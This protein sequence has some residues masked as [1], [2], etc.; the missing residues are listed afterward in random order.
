MGLRRYSPFNIVRALRRKYLPKYARASYSQ[1]GE[2]IILDRFLESQHRG[3]YVDVGAHH[4]KRFSNT[5]RLYCRGWRGLNI[6]A[7]PGCMSEFRRIR[8]RDLNVEAAVGSFPRELTF[9]VFNEPALNTFDTEL[10]KERN[11]GRW[12]IVRQIKLV[13]RPLRDLLDEHLPPGTTIDVLTVDVEGLDYEVL[14]S[15]DWERYRPTFVLAEC[16]GAVTTPEASDHPVSRLLFEKGYCIV[17]KTMYTAVFR[18][19]PM[20]KAA[21]DQPLR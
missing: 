20:R 13:T 4:P 6:D 7:I 16:F 19:D 14:E 8:P 15:S 2:D 17:A 9:Y 1:E 11:H 18:H 5:Y 12:K 3:F 21:L 10:A